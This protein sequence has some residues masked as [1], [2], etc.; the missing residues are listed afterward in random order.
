[1]RLEIE[2]YSGLG[3]KVHNNVA[4]EIVCGRICL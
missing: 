1:M 3:Y 2:R 4:I